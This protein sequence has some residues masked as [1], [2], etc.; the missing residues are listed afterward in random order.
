MEQVN[1]I[2]E[3]EPEEKS[4]IF[5]MGDT[6][7]TKRNLKSSFRKMWLLYKTKPNLLARALKKYPLEI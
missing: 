3:L 4:R 7:L 2:R 1:T 5:K 6:F